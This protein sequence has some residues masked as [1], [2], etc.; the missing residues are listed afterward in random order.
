MDVAYT[1]VTALNA[2]HSRA[3]STTPNTP[4][5]GCCNQ[6]LLLD[7]TSPGKHLLLEGV[8][9][10]VYMNTR[11]WET[12]GIPWY[13]AKL[14]ED[15][16]SY[17]DKSSERPVAWI[18]GGRHTLVYFALNDGGR[19]GAHAHFFLRALAERA[20]SQGRKSRPTTCDPNGVI[21]CS[22]GASDVS[23]WV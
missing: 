5:H 6:L 20:V 10:T 9:T 1:R 12:R 18:H 21:L 15:K 7:Y 2:C 14:V 3:R 22:D 8:V 16:K 13:A 11:Q 17:A 19:L 23:L 4:L